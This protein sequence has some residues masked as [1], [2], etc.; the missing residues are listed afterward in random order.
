MV[1]PRLSVPMLGCRSSILLNAAAR[2]LSVCLL[3]LSQLLSPS[4]L[5]GGASLVIVGSQGLNSGEDS[6]AGFGGVGGCSVIGTG[7]SE[8][9]IA[10][11]LGSGAVVQ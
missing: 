8:C 7:S 11:K 10:G 2:S 5:R 6:P 1:S 9:M 4:L 3:L